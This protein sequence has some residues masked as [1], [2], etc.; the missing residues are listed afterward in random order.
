MFRILRQNLK[1]DA[2]TP[3]VDCDAAMTAYGAERLLFGDEVHLMPDGDVLVAGLYAD[4]I[5][6]AYIDKARWREAAK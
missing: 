6:R 5:A 4:A 2:D 1:L 3:F